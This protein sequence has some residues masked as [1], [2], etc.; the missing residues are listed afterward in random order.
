MQLR[1]QQLSLHPNSDSMF[2][3]CIQNTA[4]VMF[5]GRA[6]VIRATI[7]TAATG[8]EM[9][10]CR[11]LDEVGRAEASTKLHFIRSENGGD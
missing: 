11:R 7:R 4:R 9:N 6:L 5:G 1:R 2:N 10:R 3:I 8:N